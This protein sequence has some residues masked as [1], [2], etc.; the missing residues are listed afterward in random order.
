MAAICD[1]AC[2][3]VECVFYQNDTDRERK[4]CYAIPNRYGMVHA[5][6]MIKQSAEYIMCLDDK[7]EYAI[8]YA[9]G[10]KDEI[11]KLFASY[12]ETAINNDWNW[13][14]SEREPLS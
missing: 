8:Y 5:Q 4:V 14:H 12:D 3:C 2:K 9:N 7:G 6:K 1:T 13:L 11:G 10:R